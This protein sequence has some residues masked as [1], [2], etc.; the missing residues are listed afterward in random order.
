MI[1]FSAPGV[2]EKSVFLEGN[3]DVIFWTDFKASFRRRVDARYHIELLQGGG[4]VATA[5]CDP[6]AAG[7]GVRFC[8][9]D[10]E[11][12][13]YHHIRCRLHCSA[14]VPESGPTLVRASFWIYDEE[15]NDLR[16]ERADLG[17]EQ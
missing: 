15:N 3:R 2:G 7:G 9:L 16:L 5:T 8:S 13:S 11:G 17:I 10:V 12:W 6:V 4:V 14:R 1:P